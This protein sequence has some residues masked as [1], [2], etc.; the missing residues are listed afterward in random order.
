MNRYLALVFALLFLLCPCAPAN[1]E[2]VAV[3]E[4]AY[5]RCIANTS[6]NLRAGPGTSYAIVGALPRGTTARLIDSASGWH[7]IDTGLVQAWVSAQYT[8]FISAAS[9]LSSDLISKALEAA[10]QAPEMGSAVCISADGAP[11]LIAPYAGCGSAGML[12]PQTAYPLYEKRNGYLRVRMNGNDVWVDAKKMKMSIVES[13]S[14]DNN[15]SFR[16][17]EDD[18]KQRI[19][20]LSYGADC[21][22]PYSDLRYLSILHYDFDGSVQHGEIICN[23]AVAREML[24]IFRVLFEAEYPLTMVRLVDDFDAVDRASMSANNTSCFNFRLIAGT[25]RLSNHALGL[26]IDVN[27]QINPYMKGSY[28]SPQNGA[29]Y[30]DRT[31]NFEGKIDE[32][33]LC[34]QLFI[35]YGWERGGAWT[36]VQDYQHFEKYL[37]Q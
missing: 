32:S 29:A 26:A 16:P 37:D 21:T 8:E 18:I 30:A 25:N 12:D 36:G 15:F 33:D 10:E 2:T 9:T 23:A 5:V 27:P 1:A 19:N 14:I 31:Q 3:G 24:I 34:Y 6:V 4:E 13:L 22:V 20:G 17:I 28:V 35:H 7:L 11:A